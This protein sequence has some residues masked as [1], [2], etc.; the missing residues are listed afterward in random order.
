MN[1]AI[2]KIDNLNETNNFLLFIFSQLYFVANCRFKFNYTFFLLLI[3][4]E[5][6]VIEQNEPKKYICIYILCGYFIT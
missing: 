5:K 4:F 1:N 6:N 2:K 3:L